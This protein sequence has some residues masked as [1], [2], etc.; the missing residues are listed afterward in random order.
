MDKIQLA[1]WKQELESELVE[2]EKQLTEIEK[3]RS[4]LKTQLGAVTTLLSPAEQMQVIEEY[5]TTDYKASFITELKMK[6]WSVQKQGGNN[7]NYI[8]KRSGYGAILWV[9]FSELSKVTGNYWFGVNPE[10]LENKNGG[11]VLLLG[12]HQQ[13]VCL[14]FTKLHEMLEGSKNTKTGQ[15]FQVK[16]KSG[17]VELQ[18]AGLGG[19]WIDITPY[20]NGD[21]LKKIGIN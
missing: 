9:K 12:N 19:K 1:K 7:S 5:D 20:L 4:V 14:P 3:K 18:P 8:A 15:K 16:Q 21:G 2:V 10:H 6:G 11:V 17:R 13:Y